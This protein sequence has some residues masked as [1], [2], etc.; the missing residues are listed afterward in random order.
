MPPQPAVSRRRPARV[1]PKCLRATAEERLVC[2]LQ[3]SLA[4]DVLPGAGGHAGHDSEPGIV[5][6]A[7]IFLVAP[8]TDDVAVRHDDEGCRHLAGKHA[9]WLARL[10]DQRLVFTQVR[11]RRND[12]VK[13]L[14]ISRGTRDRHIDDKVFRVLGVFQIIFEKSKDRLLPPAAAA[15]VEPAT[16]SDFS[17]AANRNGHPFAPSSIGMKRG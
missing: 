16:G 10:H 15:Q 4:A 2:A 1:P 6:S 9:D 3:N 13:A 12:A 14:P 11:Q 7:A 8:L 17:P 5:K